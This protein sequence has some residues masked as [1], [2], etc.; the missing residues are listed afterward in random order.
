M[1]EKIARKLPSDSAMR[2]QTE[3][4]RIESFSDAVFAIAATLLVLELK[5]P[6][7]KPWVV[8]W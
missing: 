8:G 5:V 1:L 6:L 7:V 2:D 3:L 4:T